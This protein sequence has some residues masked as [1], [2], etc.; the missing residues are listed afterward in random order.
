WCWRTQARFGPPYRWVSQNIYTLPTHQAAVES[1]FSLVNHHLDARMNH[2]TAQAILQTTEPQLDRLQPTREELD[3]I[4]REQS[5]HRSDFGTMADIRRHLPPAC[6]AHTAAE[7]AEQLRRQQ[8][9]PRTKACRP[10]ADCTHAP[11]CVS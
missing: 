11:R 5:G 3:A 6:E 9:R 2:E 4:R 10:G 7:R 1:Q 8:R